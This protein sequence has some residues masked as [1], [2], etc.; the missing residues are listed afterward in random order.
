VSTVAI[1]DGF[2]AT[3]GDTATLNFA[4]P[5]N[6]ASPGF[7]AEM[8]LGIGFSYDGSPCGSTASQT[9]TVAVNGTTI[10]NSAGC[11]DDSA[12]AS[13]A[14]GNL[15][16]VGGNDDAFAPMLPTV[17]QDHERYNLVPRIANGDTSISIRTSNSSSDDNIFLA[18]FQV[19][20]EA[21]VNDGGQVPEPTGLALVGLG[22]LGLGA[23]RQLRTRR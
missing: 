1:L 7:Q 16:T 8:R 11:N 14:N 3:T 20:G 9:S 13:P 2:A 5:I 18:V 22:L 4:T 6:P 10:T 15:I 23:Q 21:T 12:D 19:S 17:A